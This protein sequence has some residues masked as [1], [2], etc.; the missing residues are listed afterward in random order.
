MSE[1]CDVIV[2]GGAV[3]GSAVAY[4]LAENAD[5]KGRVIVLEKDRTYQDAASA[6]STSGVRQQFSSAVN[7][8]LAG[9]A[10][11]FIKDAGLT[12]DLAGEP[13]GVVLQENGYLYLGGAEAIADFE[14]NNRL[15]RSLGADVGLLSRSEL[16]RRF[17]WLTLDDVE[18]GSLGARGEGWTDGHLLMNAL[19]KRARANGAEYRHGE[20]VGLLRHGDRVVGVRCADGTEIAAGHTVNT[21]GGGGRAV[22]AMAGVDLPIRNMKQFVFAFESPFEAEAIP[23]V[24]TPDGLFFRPEGKG[25]IAGIGIDARPGEDARDLE[26]DHDLFTKEGWPKLAFRVAGFERTRL[27][28]AWAGHYDMNLFD[29]NAVIG[30]VADVPGF[31]LANGFSGHGLM[32]SPGVGRALSELIIYGGYRSLDLSDLSFGRIAANAP[33]RE[34]IQY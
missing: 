8:K 6:R 28:S 19:S 29:H 1:H 10:A 7:I 25:Y 18:I 21:A 16:G 12:L 24:F 11:E 15:Q 13:S 30:G 33:L 26:V 5:F 9:F 23:F 14:E 3:M 20:A 22:A 32:Q 17:P 31:Y 2:V 27:R 34:R 4:F